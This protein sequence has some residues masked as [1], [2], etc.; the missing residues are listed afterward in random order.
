MTL[1]SKR[2]STRFKVAIVLTVLFVMGEAAAGLYANSLAL[3]S[4]AAHNFTDV[5]ALGLSLYAL[6]LSARPSNATKTF[7]YH[8]AGILAA[9]VNATT[10]IGIALLIFYEAYERLVAPPPIQEQVMMIVAGVGFVINTSIAF[11]LRH[12]AQDLNVRSAF[13]HMVGDALSTLGVVIAG[14]AIHLTGWEILDPLASVLIGVL[15]A[16]SSW[17]ILR[18]GI[19]VLLEGT[20]TGIDMEAMVRDLMG[21]DGVQGVHD[22]H[23]WSISS[24]M[25]ALSAH[26]LTDDVSLS[27]G[28]DI[29][30][31]INQVLIER[32]H[33][34][35]TA[36]QLEC[37]G[38][39]PDTLYC[40][41]GANRT[42]A[43]R[44][45]RWPSE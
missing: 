41:L 25:H 36:L 30:R 5:L 32:Y 42:R 26:V 33:I 6:Y 45:T 4:D 15:I 28:A 21:I 37:E 1:S 24:S 14:F 2:V 23:A 13:I 22:L 7:G 10:L 17:G 40:E 43:A 16:V 8:R 11:F 44:N 9:L 38:C 18:E 34:G 35:H 29:Q 27:R 12:F 3:L 19:N 39:S 20:P 31:E